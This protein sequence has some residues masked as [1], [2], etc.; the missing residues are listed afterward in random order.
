M[1]HVQHPLQG[2]RID[3]LDLWLLM[4]N[5]K[6]T[7]ISC[8]QQLI[9]RESLPYIKVSRYLYKTNKTTNH[10]IRYVFIDLVYE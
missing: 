4:P 6:K 5:L 7:S 1:Q 9:Y 2:H 3:A 8:G 10:V